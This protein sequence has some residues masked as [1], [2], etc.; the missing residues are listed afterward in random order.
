MDIYGINEA[1]S[2]GNSRTANNDLFNEQILQARDN[3]NNTLDKENITAKGAVR[4]AKQDASQDKLLYEFHDTIATLGT[5]RGFQSAA[6]SY[7][8]YQ[9]VKAASGAVG[10][11]SGSAFVKS[12]KALAV[13]NAPFLKGVYGSAATANDDVGAAASGAAAPPTTSTGASTG[14]GAAPAQVETVD[15][16]APATAPADP[17]APAAPAAP[18]DTPPAAAPADAPPGSVRARA[19]AIQGAQGDAPAPNPTRP[20]PATGGG[21]TANPRTGG[22]EPAAASNNTGTPASQ[23]DTTTTIEG[24][25][26]NLGKDEEAASS[27]VN[28]GKA[29]VEGGI[30]KANFGFKALGAV[31]GA[32][33]TYELAKNGLAGTVDPKT[34]K[35]TYDVAADV[36]QVAGV[37]GAGLDILGAF[38]PVFE[39]LGAAAG[40]VAAIS[41]TLESN[42]ND[43]GKIT[44][45]QNAQG[46]IAG[47]RAAQLAALPQVKPNQAPVNTMVSTGLVAT[48]S[49]HI[50]NATQGTGSF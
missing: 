45:A 33:S 2:Q 39:P 7:K 25:T 12:Q 30:S 19:A 24:K 44:D 16:A 5:G 27:L 42:K 37:V 47:K 40:A 3:I 15:P 8:S 34:G 20:A 48:Q 4:T 49:Q 21:S 22:S 31:G 9:K 43:T 41:D 32:I 35:K 28:K 36:S 14:T 1:R 50:Q 26:S 46:S 11:F 18:A 10:G 38:I 13:E 29:A 6:E 23:P 17:A